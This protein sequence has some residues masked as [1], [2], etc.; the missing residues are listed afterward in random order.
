MMGYRRMNFR[1]RMRFGLAQFWLA[2]MMCA[3]AMMAWAQGSDTVL[4]AADAGKLLPASVYF[5]GQSA[6][7]QLRNSGG[8]KFG[9]GMYVLAVMVDTSGYATDVAQ[10]YQSYLITEDAIKIE[11]QA[12][13]PGIYGV[14]F[15]G[16]KF[17]V[18]DV[19]AHDLLNVGAHVDDGMKR[20]MPLKVTAVDGGGFRLYEGRKYVAFAR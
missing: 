20:P 5:R 9:D 8:V 16:D 13:Q 10:K 18:M 12:L 19:G 7:T 14:G 6:T 1:L 3:S 4:T 15:V 2:A 17:V 11:G